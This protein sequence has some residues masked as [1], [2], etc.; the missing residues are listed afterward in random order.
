MEKAL[1]VL[2]LVLIF[3]GAPIFLIKYSNDPE[4]ER[5]GAIVLTVVIIVSIV[6]SA[7]WSFNTLL[8]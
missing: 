6:L 4:I 8:N 2:F 1:A 3:I 5:I 7:I